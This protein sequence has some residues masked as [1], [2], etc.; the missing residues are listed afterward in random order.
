[1][2]RNRTFLHWNSIA[3][4]TKMKIIRKYWARHG[5]MQNMDHINQQNN[6]SP[7]LAVS[8][9]RNRTFLHWNCIAFLTKMKIIRK[10]WARHGN[11]RNMD[12]RNQQNIESPSKLESNCP[13]NFCSTQ[14]STS[15]SKST[16]L[17]LENW[18]RHLGTKSEQWEWILEP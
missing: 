15:D 5:N 11:M 4:L 10:Y 14:R 3:F 7:C 13:S 6:E 16:A 2:I 8:M 18:C 1:M 9:I 17:D 12:H